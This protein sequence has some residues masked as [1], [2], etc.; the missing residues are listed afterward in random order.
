[1]TKRMRIVS[2][3]ALAICCLLLLWGYR[4]VRRHLEIDSC[5]D[6]GGSWSY[7]QGKCNQ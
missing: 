7:D 3:V 4:F 6:S 5:L 1:M 2:V